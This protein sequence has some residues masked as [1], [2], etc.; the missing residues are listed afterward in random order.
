MENTL[1]LLAA[2]SPELAVL[3]TALVVLAADLVL[4]DSGRR[5]LPN[6]CL[7]GLAAAL[8]LNHFYVLPRCPELGQQPLLFLAPFTVFFKDAILVAAGLTV[9]LYQQQKGLSGIHPGEFL[10]LLLFSAAGMM[11]LVSSDDLLMVFLSMEF[12]GIISYVL[13]GYIRDDLKAGEGAVKFYLIGAFASAIMVY[14]MSLLYGLLGTT[15]ITEMGRLVGQAGRNPMLLK[16][17]VLLLS[18]GLGFKLAVVPFHSWLPDAME[19]GP[20]PVAAYISVAPKAAGLAVLIRIF[21]EAFPLDKIQMAGMLSVLAL[22]TMTFGNLM[23]IPQ[24]NV[25]RLLAY[26]SI[27]HI[28]YILIGV[29]AANELGA[30]GILVYVVAYV[31]MNLGAFACVVAVSNRIGSEEI[32]DYAG[33]SQRNLPVALLLVLFLLSL[34][35][36]PPTAGFIGKWLVFGSAIQAAQ[37]L[38]DPWASPYL[39]LVIAAV[40]NSVV[41]IYYYFRLAYQMF[42]R[43]PREATGVEGSGVLWLGTGVAAAATLLVGI[44]PSPVIDAAQSAVKLLQLWKS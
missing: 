11:F 14:G 5:H 31:F 37:A 39:W 34:G 12:I 21:G 15:S 25:K 23:A 7:L 24:R 41:S 2:L 17:A 26:S 13:V 42:F 4:T 33:L 3:Y 40:L 20:T 22:A 6:G 29:I 43:P 10:S 18:V 36:L 38:P 30:G 35:G 9:V 19:G 27:G 16:I 32:D 1:G 28:G 8:A 44:F